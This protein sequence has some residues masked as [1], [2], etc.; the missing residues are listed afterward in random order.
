MPMM[1]LEAAALGVTGNESAAELNANGAL[2]QR[3]ETLRLE[4][5]R[6]MGMGDVSNQV[7]PKPVLI[8]R[9]NKGG[10]L[11]VRYFMPHQCHPLSQRPARLGLPRPASATEPSPRN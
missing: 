8:S 2:L 1:L 9:P 4:A 3:L 7:T 11:G 6:R 5:G 10:D